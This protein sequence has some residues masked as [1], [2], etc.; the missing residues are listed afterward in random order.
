MIKRGILYSVL[1]LA[2]ALPEAQAINRV[3]PFSEDMTPKQVLTLAGAPLARIERETAR[4]EVWEYPYYKVHFR[5]GKLIDWT[6]KIA[7][8]KPTPTPTEDEIE[9]EEM[10]EESIDEKDTVAFDEILDA[11]PK[12]SDPGG[13]PSPPIMIDPEKEMGVTD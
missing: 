2:C 10:L 9:R 7:Q 12:D 8:V 13:Q 1:L 6:G 3:P 11:L 4:E 5:E